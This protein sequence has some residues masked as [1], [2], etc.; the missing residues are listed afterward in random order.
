MRRSLPAVVLFATLGALAGQAGCQQSNQVT[1]DRFPA[2]YAQA[3]CTSLQHCCAENG[4]A[5]DYA[6]CT[7]GWEAAVQNL[8]TGPGATGNYNQQLATQCIDQVRAAENGSCQPVPG[9]FQDAHDT[10]QAIFIGM[11]PTGAPCTSASQCAPV[12]GSVVDCA[13][14]PGGDDGGGGSGGGQLP[15]A[16]PGVSIQGVTISP[17]DVAVCVVLPAPD[18]APPATGPCTVDTAAGTDSCIASGGFCDTGSGACA[19]QGGDAAPCDPA[20]VASCLPSFWCNAGAC[21]AAGPVGSPCTAAVMCDATGYCDTGSG[22][23]TAIVQPGGGCTSGTQC[24]IGVCDDGTHSCLKNAI[25]T[26]EACNGTVT[27]Q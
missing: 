5:S 18:A 24:T 4:V 25:A 21:T 1:A 8:L 7:K 15:L 14:V 3:L 12:P 2:L 17:R 16:A 9:G 27:T 6:S 23:C 22:T 20:V 26:T 19:P 10:C 13:V 11:V